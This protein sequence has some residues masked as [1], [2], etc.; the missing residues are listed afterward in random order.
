MGKIR[1]GTVG[2]SSECA[3]IIHSWIMSTHWMPKTIS[4]KELEIVFK[5]SIPLREF[6]VFGDPI[7]GYLSFDKEQLQIMGLYVALRN[8][9]IGSALLNQVKVGKAFLQLW[10][11]LPNIEA[12]RFYHR[13]GFIQTDRNN[14]GSDGITEL[15]FIWNSLSKDK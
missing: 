2:D 4:I 12:H 3:N 7:L 9:G 8:K 15:K 1:N 10:S 14:S 13:E 5:K 11:H 6:W